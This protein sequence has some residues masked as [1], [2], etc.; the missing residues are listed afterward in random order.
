[1]TSKEI[2]RALLETGDQDDPQAFVQHHIDAINEPIK[3]IKVFGRRW[4]NRSCG[5][6]YHTVDIYLNGKLL[7]TTTMRYGHGGQYMDTAFAWLEDNG[8]LPKREHREPP[9]LLAD[10]MGFKFIQDVVDVKRKR[11]L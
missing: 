11:D 6:T 5:N 8:Y 2:V 4:W 7:H 3:E 10:K 1:M 9:W